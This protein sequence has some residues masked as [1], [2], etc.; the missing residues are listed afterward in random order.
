MPR[1]TLKPPAQA[2]VDQLADVDREV[3]ELAGREY[4]A[5]DLAAVRIALA[6]MKATCALVHAVRELTE[7]I[8]LGRTGTAP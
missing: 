3:R 2:M 5:S 7:Q 4:V 6:H 8:R 1:D